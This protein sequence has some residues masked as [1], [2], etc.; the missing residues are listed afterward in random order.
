MPIYAYLCSACG[1]A[2][3]SLRKLSDP[4]LTLC[5]TCHQDT[6]VKQLSA[7]GFALKGTGWYATDFRSPAVKATE[8]KKTDTESATPN[9]PA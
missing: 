5:P 7:A 9:V 1:Y 3:D 4:P 2:A 6:Y 8:V